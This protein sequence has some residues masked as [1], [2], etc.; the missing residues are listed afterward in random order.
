MYLECFFALLI[1]FLVIV[2]ASRVVVWVVASTAVICALPIAIEN[3]RLG[4]EEQ[5]LIQQRQ[6]SFVPLH[7]ALT[8][9]CEELRLI[10]MWPCGGSLS[11]E[12][13]TRIPTDDYS[14]YYLQLSD[15]LS[16]LYSTVYSL[17]DRYCTFYAHLRTDDA[18]PG[19]RVCWSQSHSTRPIGVALRLI[20]RFCSWLQFNF[21]YYIIGI[22]R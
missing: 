21:T 11:G 12:A 3:Y 13:L 16:L 1:S 6:V 7:A 4:V 19:R 10:L 18:R 2:Q 5:Q 17:Q 8:L 22:F 14:T 15:Y 9:G 20:V